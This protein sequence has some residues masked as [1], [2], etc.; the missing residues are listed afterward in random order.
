MATK[1]SLLSAINAQLTA[2]ITQAKHR[3]SMSLMLDELYPSVINDTQ[4]TTNVLTASNATDRTY[5]LRIVKQGRCVTIKGRLKNATDE[6]VSNVDF[7]TITTS[8][9][10]PSETT[11]YY[12]FGELGQVRFTLDVGGVLSVVSAMGGSSEIEINFTYFTLN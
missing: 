1:T 11:T 10:L 8:E 7:A 3:L 2:I 9:Y 6:I 5:N 12:G 4:A